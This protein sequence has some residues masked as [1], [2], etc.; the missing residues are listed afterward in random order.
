M[1]SLRTKRFVLFVSLPN[2]LCLIS[3]ADT[4]GMGDRPVCLLAGGTDLANKEYLMVG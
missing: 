1:S 2:S 3:Q 4:W